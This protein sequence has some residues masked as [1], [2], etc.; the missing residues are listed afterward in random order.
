MLLYLCQPPRV[1]FWLADWIWSND[2][3]ESMQWGRNKSDLPAKWFFLKGYVIGYRC[4][5]RDIYLCMY[6]SK[7]FLCFIVFGNTCAWIIFGDVCGKLTE[8]FTRWPV[9]S[10]FVVES[11]STH[12]ATI[13]RNF[14]LYSTRNSFILACLWVNRTCLWVIDKRVRM[15]HSLPCCLFVVMLLCIA[16][17]SW[18]GTLTQSFVPQQ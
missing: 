17:W 1:S 16:D 18:H 3:D 10:Y 11:K 13:Y 4:N 7:Y 9:R 12:P 15:W 8:I 2:D 14:N 6:I 5:V